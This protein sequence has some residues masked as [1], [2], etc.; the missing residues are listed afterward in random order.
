MLFGPE[1]GNY[2]AADEWVSIPDLVATTEILRRTLVSL[3]GADA[4]DTH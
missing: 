1:G 4:T 2:H 3:L